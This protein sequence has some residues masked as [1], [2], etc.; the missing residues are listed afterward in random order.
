MAPALSL[1]V[2]AC[3]TDLSGRWAQTTTRRQVDLILRISAAFVVETNA[4]L[5]TLQQGE[6]AKLAD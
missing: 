1:D 5:L 4:L 6:R 2:A 3:R